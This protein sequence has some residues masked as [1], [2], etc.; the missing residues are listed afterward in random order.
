[1]GVRRGNFFVRGVYLAHRDMVGPSLSLARL[2]GR[3]A[4]GPVGRGR[5]TFVSASSFAK[6]LPR[7]VPSRWEASGGVITRGNASE[8]LPPGPRNSDWRKFTDLRDDRDRQRGKRRSPPPGGLGR[9]RRGGFV[10]RGADRGPA[11]PDRAR[12]STDGIQQTAGF[13]PHV[14]ARAMGRGKQQPGR[15]GGGSPTELR[16]A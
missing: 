3:S 2:T 8:Q 15:N 4:A 9:S 6:F 10:A 16:K 5:G 12:S 1:M 11:R 7:F 13:A 14:H